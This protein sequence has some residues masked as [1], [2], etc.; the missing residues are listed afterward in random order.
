MAE[1]DQLDALAALEPTDQV[2]AAI[3]TRTDLVTYLPKSA[4]DVVLVAVRDDPGEVETILRGRGFALDRV[5][6]VPVGLDTTGY[7]GRMDV[8]D[9]VRPSN[10]GKVGM[11]LS[12]ALKEATDG[13]WLVLDDLSIL[14]L[15]AER[16]R[17][18][19]FLEAVTD[20]ARSRP[21]RGFYGV[22]RDAVTDETFARLQT[23][24]DTTVELD[25]D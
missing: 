24:M 15:Y 25:R 19:R 22:V 12:R 17:V 5:T 18:I 13:P 7:D 6:V 23:V 21:A 16:E 2:L 8:L 20:H 9:T 3:D 14:L 1:A 4:G 11:L 10:L